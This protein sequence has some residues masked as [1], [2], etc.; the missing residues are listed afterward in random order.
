MSRTPIP[1][2]LEGEAAPEA[3]AREIQRMFASISK[4]YDLL[5]RLLSFGFDQSWRRFSAR[6][7]VGPGI[8]RVLDVCGGTG[9][10]AMAYQK[11]MGGRGSVVITDF[12]HEMVVLARQKAGLLAGCVQS[13]FC[14]AD[15]LRL[16]FRDGQFDLACVGF[17][18]RNVT[19]PAGCLREMARVVRPGGKVVILEFSQPPNRV[20]RGLYYLYFRH[21]LPR[22]GRF[23]S[24]SPMDAYAYLPRSVLKFFSPE[25][26]AE[27]M[28]EAGLEEVS[29]RRRVFG[30][31]ALH[32]G[33]K[34]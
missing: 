30:I 25:A 31:V 20:F 33:T 4:R 12:C 21:I 15:A 24:G 23:V 11:E 34:P 16:P 32:I 1:I 10:L 13:S 28:E 5:N 26:L 17:G 2:S 22:I 18:I 29:Y 19:D 9:D 6:S 14:Q 27:E 7:T 8:R 3:R